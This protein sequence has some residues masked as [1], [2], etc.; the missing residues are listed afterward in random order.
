MPYP[1]KIRDEIVKLEKFCDHIVKEA[2][3]EATKVNGLRILTVRNI[4]TILI[5]LRERPDIL[6]LDQARKLL[7]SVRNR[8]R[9][10][11][12]NPLTAG[13]HNFAL[14]NDNNMIPEIPTTDADPI[15]EKIFELD[16]N[17]KAAEDHERAKIGDE[18]FSDR[19]ELRAIRL[20]LM[21][22]LTSLRQKRPTEIEFE[23]EHL[24]NRTERIFRLVKSNV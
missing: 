1:K 23:L 15:I 2:K 9:E 10:L 7:S 5:N 18:N 3:K 12:Y 22:L 4:L 17:C 6:S 8:V 16:A 21:N 24:K 11:Y 20:Q 13:S 14:K 19:E